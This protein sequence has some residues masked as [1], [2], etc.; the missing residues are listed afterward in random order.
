MTGLWMGNTHS[1]D[2]LAAALAQTRARL[3]D[4]AESAQFLAQ[5]FHLVARVRQQ[6]GHLRCVSV[7]S[8][9]SSLASPSSPRGALWVAAAADW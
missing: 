4:E 6:L 5:N 1:G 7:A 2:A 8:R 9:A 3:L